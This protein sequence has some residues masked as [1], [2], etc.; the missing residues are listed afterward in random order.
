MKGEESRERK[1]NDTQAVHQSIVEVDFDLLVGADGAHSVTRQQ[2]SRYAK[3]NFQQTWV[4]ILWCEF[5]IPFNPSGGFQLSSDH[6]H[7]WPQKS[8]MFI[9]S[10]NMNGTF[11]SQLFAPQAI[12]AEFE[13]NPA[14]IVEFFQHNFPGV[15]PNLIT[16]EALQTQFLRNQHQSLVDI[17]C[18]PYH[19]RDSCVIVGD[20]AHAMM[21]FYGQGLNTGFE[22]VRILFEDYLDNS[23]SLRSLTTI[24][25][26]LHLQAY[27]AFRH[28]DTH[29][30]N[31]LALQHLDTLLRV[32]DAPLSSCPTRLR[33]WI[34][35]FLS[36]QAPWLGWA[37]LYSRVAFENGRYSDVI[38]QSRRQGRVLQMCAKVTVTLLFSTALLLLLKAVGYV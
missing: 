21:P 26:P 17:K 2:L 31:E 6:L 18:S 37:T 5:Q 25:D 11:T 24:G 19:Y 13:A 32:G 7:L 20:A 27:S 4:D 3:I 1:I 33:T 35:E 12:F 36:L 30:M 34:E 9:A 38:R 8:C 22:D 23:C 14:G 29:A 10:P 16:P 28:P 15:T